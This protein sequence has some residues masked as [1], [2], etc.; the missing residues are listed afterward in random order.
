MLKILNTFREK[1]GLNAYAR[2]DYDNA[3][4]WFRKLEKAEPDSLRV[5]RNLGVILLAK[6]DADGAESYIKREE[7][8]FGQSFHRHAAL[9]DLA[10]AR[11]N[12]EQAEKRYR[13]ALEEP[14]CAPGGS[15]EKNKTLIE[16]RRDICADVELF[17]K[18]RK[19]MEVFQEAEAHRKAGEVEQAIGCYVRAGELDETSWFA[20]NNAGS[21]YLNNV[22]DPHKAKEMLEKAFDISKNIQV[23]RNLDLAIRMAEKGK[24]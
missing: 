5:L 23:A 24:A 11:G 1:A 17:A 22:G 19:S 4:R 21:L 7:K 14:E 12:R 8:L 20:W 6:G 13:L 18:S 15:A 16:K 10:Y 9:A 2:G 3:E